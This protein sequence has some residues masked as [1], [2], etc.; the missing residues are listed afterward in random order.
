MSTLHHHMSTW[1]TWCPHDPHV[2][3]MST[4]SSTSMST[5]QSTREIIQRWWGRDHQLRHHL[6]PAHLRREVPQIRCSHILDLSN[7]TGGLRFGLGLGADLFGLRIRILAGIL[8]DN[9]LSAGSR[10]G[11]PRRQKCWTHP[12]QLH[13]RTL[14]WAWAPC[15]SRGIPDQNPLPSTDEAYEQMAYLVLTLRLFRLVSDPLLDSRGALV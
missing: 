11:L 14:S 5:L 7:C 13:S 15:Y 4:W 3:S 1:S 12:C 2:H 9:F 8:L 10:A 6:A